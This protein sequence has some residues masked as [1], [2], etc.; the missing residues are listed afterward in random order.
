MR[1]AVSQYLCAVF[2]HHTRDLAALTEAFLPLPPSSAAFSADGSMIFSSLPASQ[3]RCQ[4]PFSQKA[5]RLMLQ[6]LCWCKV[7]CFPRHT[8]QAFLSHLFSFQP[9][10]T[11]EEDKEKRKMML[12]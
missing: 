2:S 12:C 5:P 6:T 4:D 8:M 1:T 3:K 10:N 7:L 11:L 9:W